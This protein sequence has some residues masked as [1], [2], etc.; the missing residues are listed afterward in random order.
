MTKKLI[1]TCALVLMLPFAAG[2]QQHV[3]YTDEQIL[4]MVEHDLSQKEI[5]GVKV[6]VSGGVVSLEGTVASA[7]AKGQAADIARSIHDVKDV[8][9]DLTI[10]P[11]EGGD[12]EL[13]ARIRSKVLRYVFYTMFDEVGLSVKN[14]VVTL[15]GRVT[16]PYKAQEI[17]TL[18]S[19]ERGVQQVDNQIEVLP[20]SPSDDQLRNQLATRIYQEFPDYAMQSSPPIH[21]IVDNGHV[22]LL[23]P[24]R[25]EV[26]R[27]QIVNIARS[28]F[29]VLGVDDKLTVASS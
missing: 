20:F 29:G 19:K 12:E 22:T 15:V 25:N 21:I 27:H 2:A 14:G 1:V 6:D 7:W 10:A 17:A 13:A 24:I 9:N 5:D 16:M 23:G 26:E 8:R 3:G 18:A 4:T 28:T 11:V